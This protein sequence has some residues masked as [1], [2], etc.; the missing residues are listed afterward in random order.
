MI[1]SE[2]LDLFLPAYRAAQAEMKPVIKDSANPFFK[3][4]YADLAAVCNE[5][6]PIL[7]SHGLSITQSIDT[8]EE[9]TVVETVIWHDSGQFLGG[10][11]MLSPIADKGEKI[12][13]QAV[14]SA[15]TYARRYAYMAA[16]AIPADD[17]DGNAG[18]GRG[19]PPPAKGKGKDKDA[20]PANQWEGKPVG[21][22]TK[23]QLT[24]L[25]KLAKQGG[26]A[27][28]MI[29]AKAEC[30]RFAQLTQAEAAD[31]IGKMTSALA[32]TAA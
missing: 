31:L 25:T 2:A 17:D 8:Y 19:T 9:N 10:R 6:T 30:A 21:D 5:V 15:I 29:A 20:P 1:R 4:K 11:L 16:V 3:S 27:E 22:A 32:G 23:D 14:G 24:E 12:T 28:V 7:N 18:S 26:W 13:P